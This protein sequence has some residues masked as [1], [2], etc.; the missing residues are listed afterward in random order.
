[1]RPGPADVGLSGAR[2]GVHTGRVAAGVGPPSQSGGRRCH[3]RGVS[4]VRV[5][6]ITK[7]WFE[8]AVRVWKFEIAACPKDLGG[9]VQVVDALQ[10]IG[11]PIGTRC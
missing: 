1:M 6:E 2:A 7:F 8:L 9:V 3:A 10:R 5:R 11:S 4:V